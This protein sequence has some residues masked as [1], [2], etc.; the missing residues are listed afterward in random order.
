MVSEV[1]PS[2]HGFGDVTAEYLALREGCGLVSGARELLWVRGPDAVTFLDGQLSQDIAGMPDGTVARSFLLEPRGRPV[3]LLWVLRGEQ[4]VGLVADAGRG[5]PVSQGLERFRFRVRAEIDHEAMPL[6]DLWGPGSRDVLAA[7]ALPTPEGWSGGEGIVVAA[8]PA[9]V[10]RYTVGGVS[11]P[12]LAAAG[13]VRVGTLATTAVRIEIGEPVMGVD[14]DESTIPHETGLVPE[15]VSLTKGCYL[16]QELVARIDSRGRVNRHLRGLEVTENVIPP[17]GA[18]IVARDREVGSITSVGESLTVRAP[19]AMGM[20]RR[21]VEPGDRVSLVW[22]G[23]ETTAV[24][25]ALPL[26]G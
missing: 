2:R 18:T 3:A 4:R 1:A 19:V 15:L 6:L 9:G 5:G 21:E 20:V 23:G 10:S 22:E 14:V 13:A 25:R 7:A 16:G 8:I 26:V 17:E 24:V 12:D 11:A